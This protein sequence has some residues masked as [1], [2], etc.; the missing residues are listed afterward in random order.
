MATWVRKHFF[1]FVTCP[2]R[3][4]ENL[5]STEKDMAHISCSKVAARHFQYF[6]YGHTQCS[7]Y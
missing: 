2:I 6:F 4:T 1:I 3:S 7:I 5:V